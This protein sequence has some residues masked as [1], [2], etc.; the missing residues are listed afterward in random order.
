MC[1]NSIVLQCVLGGGWLSDKRRETLGLARWGPLVFVFFFF[2][3]AA[4]LVAMTGGPERCDMRVL[5]LCV[6]PPAP[7]LRRGSFK[8]TSKLGS[9]TC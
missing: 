1:L 9:S 5:G 2:P 6:S 7:V 8:V 3:K 4:V